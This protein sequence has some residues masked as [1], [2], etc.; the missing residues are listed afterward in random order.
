MHFKGMV[1]MDLECKEIP[2]LTHWKVRR[3]IRYIHNAPT[4]FGTCMELFL[5]MVQ[6]V[7]TRTAQ[8]FI[9]SGFAEQ[10]TVFT[11]YNTV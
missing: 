9:F 10:Y 1:L 7:V 8:G 3:G 11:L 4:D 5:C 2:R 6:F